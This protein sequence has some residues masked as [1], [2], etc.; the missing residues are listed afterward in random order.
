MRR[1]DGV[2]SGLPACKISKA[3]RRAEHQRNS[4]RG[5]QA[6]GEEFAASLI[7]RV[8]AACSPFRPIF[9]VQLHLHGGPILPRSDKERYSA[10]CPRG[11][12]KRLT[13]THREGGGDT[14][15]I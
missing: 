3:A 8:E 1:G 9:A 6:R 2:A 10:S 4:M 11:Y 5:R 12:D 13:E 15:G 14:L 7:G